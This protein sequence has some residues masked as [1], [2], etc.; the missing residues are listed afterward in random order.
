MTSTPACAWPAR[1]KAFWKSVNGTRPRTI[2]VMYQ[3]PYSMVTMV[4]SR[5][6]ATLRLSSLSWSMMH[7][8]RIA[9]WSR[10]P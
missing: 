7:L 10:L 4:S 8:R 2:L 3:P 9:V 6:P 5:I 1:A